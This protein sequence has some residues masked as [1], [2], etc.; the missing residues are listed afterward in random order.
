MSNCPNDSS[1]AFFLADVLHK[2]I[3]LANNSK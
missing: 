3:F 2:L 1:G